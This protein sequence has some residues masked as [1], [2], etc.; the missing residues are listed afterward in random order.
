M[1]D[2][3]LTTYAPLANDI[4]TRTGLDPATILGVID[5]ETGHGQHVSGNNIFGIT[6]G[7][8]VAGYPDVQT[9]A[10]AFIS[11]MQTPRYAG[12]ATAPDPA[13]QAA[14]LVKGGYNTANPAY[15]AIVARSAQSA[16]KQL[17]YQDSS[18]GAAQPGVSINATTSQPAS[19]PDYNPP[20][21][22]AAPA[23]SAPDYNTPAR[24]PTP[25][26]PPAP[27]QPSGSAKDRVLAD[28]ALSGD[29]SA[30]PAQPPGTAA[31]APQSAKDRLLADP[32]LQVPEKPA[33]T[34]EPPVQPTTWRGVARN[35]GAGLLD[36]AGNVVNVMSDPVGNLVIHPLAVAGGTAY[37]AAARAFGFTPMTPEQRADLY[38]QPQPGQSQLPPE[39][40]QVGTRAI[41]ALD[42][43]IP[44]Q[45]A[46]NLPASPVEQNVRAA[47]GGA[48]TA[49][50]LAPNALIAGLAGGVGASIGDVAA[51]FVP[52]WLKP[53]AELAG[54]V[55]GAF[56]VGAGAHAV[57]TP[58]GLV[59]A[60]KAALVDTAIKKYDI[61]MEARDLTDDPRFAK[62]GPTSVTSSAAKQDAWQGAIIKEMGG[63]EDKFTPTVMS[64]TAARTGRVYDDIAR[65]TTINQPSTDNLVHNDL[66]AIEAN[67][68]TT[69]GLTDSDKASIRKRMDEIVSAVQS[70]GTIT[71]SDYRALTRT[72]SPLDRLESN[73]N[74]EVAKVAGDIRDSLDGAFTNSASPADQ[75]ALTKNNYQ[76][77]IMKT[78]QDLAAKSPDGNIDGGQF[79][80]KV[81]AASRRFDPTLGGMA[82][83][84]G[85]N[86]GELAKIG[87]MMKTTPDFAPK[88]GPIVHALKAAG[89]L[90]A[91]GAPAYFVHPG[92]AAVAPAL[93]IAYAARGA[94]LPSTA[95]RNTMIRNALNPPSSPYSGVVGSLATGGNPLNRP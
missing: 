45:T 59:D 73:S 34:P 76:Y 20:G 10:N 61:P 56:S 86:I 75:A 58:V 17:G 74:P 71:G 19:A 39:Q 25:V 50:A 67:L 29:S 5:T 18:G 7:G 21:S 32:A 90:A 38:G 84:G 55:A 60:G 62:T 65:R 24:T 6:P 11:L 1:A 80:T 3:F 2:D 31:A 16:A 53:G 26:A 4:A 54:N 78:V 64:D 57:R 47:T 82:Y 69:A 15:A 93:G 63:S 70:N 8:R 14:A 22:P 92:L 79:M 68:D 23:A 94:Y 12:V 72:N 35:V 83:T 81:A 28:P 52:D 48:A 42:A 91:A 95:A 66:A 13:S 9:A 51:R 37:D 40:Q 33:D 85:G 36:A 89:G 27:A 49:A 46:A 87:A 41:N 30:A 77:R 44:G 43:A 88:T